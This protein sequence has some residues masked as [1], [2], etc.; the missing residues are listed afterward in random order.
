VPKNTPADITARLVK[1]FLETVHKE[2]YQAK[3]MSAGFVPL[4]LNGEQSVK[5]IRAETEVIKKLLAEQDLLLK[6]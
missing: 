1:A 3:I 2:E 4:I 6:K 5:Y